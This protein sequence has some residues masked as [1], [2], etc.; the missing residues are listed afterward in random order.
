MAN[1][2]ILQCLA[3]LADAYPKHASEQFGPETQRVYELALADIDPAL[4]KAATLA[5]IATGKW[6]PA[7]AELRQQAADLVQRSTGQ[8]GAYEAWGELVKQLRRGYS[9][10]RPP[11]LDELTRGALDAIGGWRWFC[12]SDNPAAD[13]ARFI[14]AYE[15]LLQRQ[16]N[17][18]MLLPGVVDYVKQLA[19]PG[20]AQAAVRE[21]AAKLGMRGALAGGNAA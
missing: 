17:D 16:T 14:Q 12:N 15:Q 13:R 10:H 18:I 2:T 9:I 5:H 20:E 7:V 19:A 6:F 8:M 4:L 11:P 21:L 3:L 1:T